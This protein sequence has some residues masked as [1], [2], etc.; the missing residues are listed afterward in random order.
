MWLIRRWENNDPVWLTG[1]CENK[2]RPCVV[3]RTLGKQTTLLYV[4]CRIAHFVVHQTETPGAIMTRVR[5]PV[6]ARDLSHIV[7]FQC[8]FSYGARIAP[9]PVCNRMQQYLCVLIAKM[10]INMYKKT[11]A[12][13]PLSMICS[14]MFNCDKA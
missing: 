4:W 3:D 7:N 6:A 10:C 12:F 5:V 8:R 11:N 13:L 14:E 9:P 2:E 1:R